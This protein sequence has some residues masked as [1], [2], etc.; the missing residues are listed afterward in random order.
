MDDAAATA[1]ALATISQLVAEWAE[2]KD[3]MALLQTIPHIM[4]ERCEQM[5][6]KVRARALTCVR[7]LLQCVFV[8]V[9]V[10]AC[11]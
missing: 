3:V 7:A 11:V 10:R 4:P 6:Y 2:G 8:C 9:R 5:N 1:E